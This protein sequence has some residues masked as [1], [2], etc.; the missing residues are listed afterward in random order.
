[1]SWDEDSLH[2]WLAR[3]PAP[4]GLSGS[5]G[6]DAAVLRA[7]RG[8]PVVCVDSCIEGVHFERGADTRLVG[9]KAAR[10]ALSDLAATGARP[11]ALLLALSAPRTA[12]ETRLRAL[13]QGVRGA[14]R[15]AG[16]D[17]VGGDLACCR[18]PLHL[19]VSAL[20][21]YEFAGTPP[22]R[23]RARA[24]DLLLVSG[25]LGG[26][27][28]GRHLRFTPRFAE[29]RF[30]AQQGAHALMDISDGLAWDLF[31][32]ARTA[33]V[34]IELELECVPLH[35]DARRRA[36]SALDHALHD[37][38]DHELVACIAPAR[39][40]RCAARARRRFPRMR[41]VGRVLAGEGLLLR[42][43]RGATRRWKRGEG[44]WSHG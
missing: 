17:L 18:G 12:S 15:R 9:G 32:L 38:E 33:G 44:G 37:G 13:I 19:S 20:G 14:A 35:R 40:K 23:A 30:L 42:D 5:R 25:P 28:L 21:E 27:R 43:V 1:M 11:R 2:R 29:G 22:G 3:G 16:A 10:R 41:V 7:L 39:W 8:R 36:G 6:H 26:S 4:R 24:G 31:R 34:A